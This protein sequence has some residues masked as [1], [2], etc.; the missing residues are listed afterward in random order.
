MFLYLKLFL[1]IGED[2]RGEWTE[3]KYDMVFGSD[4][5]FSRVTTQN[6]TSKHVQLFARIS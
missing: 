4:G 3:H 1:H 2:E 6:A 5:A